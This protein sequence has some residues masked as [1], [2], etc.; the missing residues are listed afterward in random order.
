MSL[1]SLIKTD[2][3]AEDLLK[4][5]QSN[6]FPLLPAGWYE[7]TIAEVEVIDFSSKDDSPYKQQGFKVLNT[8]LRILDGA[9]TGAKRTFFLRVPLFQRYL[10]SE[11]NPQ[12]A[13][14]G[15]YFDFFLALGFS[16]ED[17][18][19]GKVAIDQAALGGKRI[20]FQLVVKKRDDPKNSR[21]TYHTEDWN[22][23]GRVRAPKSIEGVAEPGASA[24]GS[25]FQPKVGDESPWGSKPQGDSN[26][27]AAAE[28]KGAF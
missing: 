9:P 18:A 6:D 27:Q 26:L 20:G 11:K 2:N 14:A 13:V 4:E 10:P 25:A 21:D 5:S 22:E 24:V 28:G 15:T 23:V 8:K 19:G 3:N 1:A 7:A 17:V 16:K 12:G